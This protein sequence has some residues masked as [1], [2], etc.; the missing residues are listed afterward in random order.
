MAAGTHTV[1]SAATALCSHDWTDA[2]PGL[3]GLRWHRQGVH[4]LW[5]SGGTRPSLQH[6]CVFGK[7]LNL[8]QTEVAGLILLAGLTPDF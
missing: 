2:Y 8:S 5:E 4:H 1:S 3:Q 6:L 7:A